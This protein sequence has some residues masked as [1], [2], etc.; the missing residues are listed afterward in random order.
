MRPTRNLARLLGV[1]SVPLLTPPAWGQSLPAPGTTE[2]AEPA[3]ILVAEVPPPSDGRPPSE[4]SSQPF[5]PPLHC[6]PPHP[7]PPMAG[8]GGLPQLL[9]SL[10]TEIGIRSG[11]LDAWRDFSD[12]LLVVATPPGPPPRQNADA[13]DQTKPEPFTLARLLAEDA[14]KRG[15]GA[16]ALIR[17]IDALR[18]KLTPQQLQK[19]AEI[20]AR[21]GPPASGRMPP[22][23]PP[24]GGFGPGPAGGHPDGFGPRDGVPPPPAR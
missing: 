7:M 8:P 6:G 9:S 21:L 20:E 12:A 15:R 14:L 5:G 16:E 2:I 18:G 19:I 23:G 11:Q 3:K 17:A 24:P 4:P 22:S 13:Q 1:V 10:E